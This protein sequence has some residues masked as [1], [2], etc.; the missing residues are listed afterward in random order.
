MQSTHVSLV[1]NQ[2]LAGGL[3]IAQEAGVRAIMQLFWDED[4]AAG[5]TCR[6]RLHCD[7]CD[8]PRPAP[9]FLSYDGLRF[10]NCCAI[11]FEI[12]QMN[13]LVSSP[14]LFNVNLS[15]GR[16]EAVIRVRAAG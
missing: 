3:T 7:G 12:D 13:G 6:Q 11:Q 14:H 15:A 8:L 10:C 5:R 16:P 9:G 2:P 1:E 4:I